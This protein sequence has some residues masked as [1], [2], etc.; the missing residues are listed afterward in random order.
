MQSNEAIITRSNMCMFK[1]GL[2]L[3]FFMIKTSIENLPFK[4]VNELEWGED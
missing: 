1:E 3:G 4:T 2:N